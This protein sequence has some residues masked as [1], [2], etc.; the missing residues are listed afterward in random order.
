MVDMVCLK[1]ARDNYDSARLFSRK[2]RCCNRTDICG[3]NLKRGV[4]WEKKL[5]FEIDFGKEVKVRN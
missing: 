5:K 2:A 4:L 3:H 1:A